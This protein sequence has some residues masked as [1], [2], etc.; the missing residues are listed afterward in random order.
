MFWLS[1]PVKVLRK[2]SHNPGNEYSLAQTL[3]N[4]LGS[5]RLYKTV[6]FPGC[7]SGAYELAFLQTLRSRHKFETVVM[8]DNDICEKDLKIWRNN[9]RSKL[10]VLRSFEALCSHLEGYNE[11]NVLF[12][13]KAKEAVEDKHY[14]RFVDTCRERSGQRQYIHAFVEGRPYIYSSDW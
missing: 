12:F 1:D 3:A 9:V 7:G 8:M 6:V 14:Q 4:W 5:K 11:F 2:R 13:H 10:V